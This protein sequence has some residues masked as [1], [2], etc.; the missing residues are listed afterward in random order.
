MFV[1]EGNLRG[2]DKAMGEGY[3]TVEDRLDEATAPSA[4]KTKYKAI[5]LLTGDSHKR[6]LA[7]F[8]NC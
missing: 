4:P 7:R 8:G 5:D 1:E 6:W 3:K 2:F